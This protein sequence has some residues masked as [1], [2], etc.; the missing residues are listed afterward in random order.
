MP[1]GRIV[2]GKAAATRKS[3]GRKLNRRRS[4]QMARFRRS[5]GHKRLKG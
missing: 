1:N 2:S 3:R 4:S 5:G